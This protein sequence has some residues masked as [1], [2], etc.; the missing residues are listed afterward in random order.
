MD[1]RRYRALLGASEEMD[2]LLARDAPAISFS[3]FEDLERELFD[4]ISAENRHRDHAEVAGEDGEAAESS[5]AEGTHRAG[6]EDGEAAERRCDAEASDEADYGD[7]SAE[8]HDDD[9]DE[10]EEG[11]AKKRRRR[12]QELMRVDDSARQRQANYKLYKN[13]MQKVKRW[14]LKKYHGQLPTWFGPGV[15]GESRAERFAELFA[16]GTSAFAAAILVARESFTTM[17]DP[18]GWCTC[19]RLRR[20][21][22][23]RGLIS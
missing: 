7:G 4:A 5:D 13:A 18:R 8:V 15:P 3:G 14:L 6:D 2:G 1:A 16:E 12:L 19:L 22:L 11:S 20:H 21:R 23:V 9:A 10:E 17:N